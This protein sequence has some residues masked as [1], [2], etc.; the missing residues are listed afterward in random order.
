MNSTPQSLHN[1]HTSISHILLHGSSAANDGTHANDRELL[2]S[3][4]EANS[5]WIATEDK[6]NSDQDDTSMGVVYV[7]AI[8]RII[9]R[10]QAQG[11]PRLFARTCVHT[12]STGYPGTAEATVL[13]IVFEVPK[14]PVGTVFST[15]ASVG[16]VASAG[17][18]ASVVLIGIRI[19]QLR[20]IR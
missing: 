9:R 16:T 19:R 17:T 15:V 1:T 10:H 8:I 12:N 2:L 18:L 6:L 4:M 3:F 14:L 20:Q 13:N 11:C 7:G 5:K